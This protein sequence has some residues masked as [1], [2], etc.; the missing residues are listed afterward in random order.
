[1]VILHVR[2]AIIRTCVHQRDNMALV[3]ARG[4]RPAP[5][6]SRAFRGWPDPIA[7]I[8]RVPMPIVGLA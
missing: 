3:Y 6:G 4:E 7:T 8:V 2:F 1:V 5:L